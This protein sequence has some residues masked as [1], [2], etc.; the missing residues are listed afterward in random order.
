MYFIL[1]GVAGAYLGHRDTEGF[2]RKMSCEGSEKSLGDCSSSTTSLCRPDSSVGLVCFNNVN[3]VLE[4]RLV[5]GPALRPNTHSGRLEVRLS[6]LMP[7]GSVCDDSFQGQSATAA[8]RQMGY[9][10]GESLRHSFWESLFEEE[11]VFGSSERTWLDEVSCEPGQE[12]LDCDHDIWGYHDCDPVEDV[13]VSC[14]NFSVRLLS[15][16]PNDYHIG[17]VEVYL[18]RENGWFEV[19]DVDWDD[20]DARVACRELGFADGRALCCNS[21]GSVSYGSLTAMGSM[22]NFTCT[23]KEESLTECGMIQTGL[24][25][26]NEAIINLAAVICYDKPFEEIDTTLKTRVVDGSEHAGILEVQYMGVWGRVCMDDSIF[27]SEFTDNE[28]SVACRMMGKGYSGGKRINNEKTDDIYHAWLRGLTCL[29]NESSIEDCDHPAWGSP[30]L[31]NCEGPVRV[32]CYKSALELVIQ[33]PAMGVDVRGVL[34]V[35]Y[36]GTTSVVCGDDWGDQEANAACRTIGYNGGRAWVPHTYDHSLVPILSGV[37][38]RKS[39]TNFFQ[40]DNHGW[41]IPSEECITNPKPAGIACFEETKL[42]PGYK[43]SGVLQLF[44]NKTST[45]STICRNGFDEIDAM[46]A[47]K[48]YGFSQGT[49][50]PAGAFGIVGSDVGHLRTS[51]NCTGSE[52]HITDCPYDEDIV[53]CNLYGDYV[54]VSC[55]NEV[56]TGTFAV[57]NGFSDDTQAVGVLKI[58]QNNTWG[59]ACGQTFNELDA[60][61]FCKELGIA[62]GHSYSGGVSF[63]QQKDVKGPYFVTFPNCN[64]SEERYADCSSSQYLCT[65]AAAASVLCYTSGG[66]SLE[67]TGHGGPKQGARLQLN[68]NNVPGAI[69]ANKWDD[70]DAS[71][72]CRQLSD[73]YKRGVATSYPR[74][75][76]PIYLSGF[77]CNGEEDH[78]FTCDNDGWKP[79][80]SVSNCDENSMEAGVVCFGRVFFTEIKQ[81]PDS[82]SGLLNVKMEDDYDRPVC[83]ESTFTHREAKAV[84]DE[85]GYSQAAILTPKSLDEDLKYSYYTLTKVQCLEENVHLIDCGMRVGQCPTQNQVRLLCY[86]YKIDLLSEWTVEKNDHGVVSKAFLDNQYIAAI[87]P[88]DWDDADADTFC[89]ERGHTGGKALG[90]TPLDQMETRELVWFG[91]SVCSDSPNGRKQC[92]VQQNVS[93]GCFGQN[94]RAGVLC[95]TGEEITMRLVDN[96]KVSKFAGRVE[97]NYQNVWGTIC[98]KDPNKRLVARTVCQQLGM[99]DGT[100]IMASPKRY[101]MTDSPIY[102]KNVDCSASEDSI[103]LCSHDGWGMDEGCTHENDLE[104]LCYSNVRIFPDAE[105]PHGAVSIYSGGS[106]V[107]LCSEGFTD[108]EADVIC[109]SLFYNSGKAICCSALPIPYLR[110]GASNAHCSGTESSLLDCNLNMDRESF[111]CPSAKYASVACS[112]E[113]VNEYLPFLERGDRGRV[114]IRYYGLTGSVCAKGFTHNDAKVLCRELGFSTG[115]AFTTTNTDDLQFPWLVTPQC[116]G[117]ESSLS[118]CPKFSLGMAPAC[119]EIATVQCLPATDPGK[120]EVRIAD[121]PGAVYGIPKVKI[122]GTWGTICDDLTLSDEEAV[123]LCK[124]LGGSGGTF[125]HI[126]DPS[127][128]SRP[129]PILTGLKC[130]GDESSISQCQMYAF[131]FG[132]MAESCAIRFDH[133]VL[134]CFNSVELVQGPVQARSGGLVLLH[135]KETDEWHPV[136]DGTISDKEASVICKNFGYQYGKQQCCNAFGELEETANTFVTKLS[137]PSMDSLISNCSV[138]RGKACPTEGSIASVHCRSSPFP[139]ENLQIVHLPDFVGSPT[140]Q[141]YGIEGRVCAEG[142]QEKEANVICKERGYAKGHMLMNS[143]VGTGSTFMVG[144]LNCSGTETRISDCD[145]AVWNSDGSCPNREEPNV[146]CTRTVLNSLKYQVNTD[147][148]RAEVVVDGTTYVLGFHSFSNKEAA[149]F[150]KSLGKGYLSG[151]TLIRR[152]PGTVQERIL[153]DFISCSGTESS[154]LECTGSLLPEAPSE[155][156]A[157]SVVYVECSLGAPVNLNLMLLLEWLTFFFRSAVVIV[158][159]N[160]CVSSAVE[161]VQGPVQARSGGLVLLH[162]KETDEWHPVCDGTISDKEASVICK[163]FGY[164]YGKQQCCNAFGELEETANTFVTKLSCPSMDSLISNCSVSRGK[165]CPTEGS[166]ASVHCRSSPFPVENLQIVHLPDFVGSPTVQRYGIEGRVCA[167]GFQEKEANVICKE[168]GY[169]KGHML[170]NS[171]VGTGSTFMVGSLNCSGTETRISDCDYAVW[172]SDGSCPNREEPN[173]LCTRTVLNSLKYQVNTDSGRA[174]V[175]VDGTTYVLGFHS[176]SNKEAAVFCKSLGKGYLS[177][178]TLIRRVPGTVQERILMDFISC[179]GTESSILECTG[180]LLPEAPSEVTADSVVY[181]ECSLGVQL[182]SGPT[183]SSGILSIFNTQT[184]RY[185]VVCDKDFG[186]KEADVACKTLGYEKGIL[187]CCQAYGY[188][189]EEPLFK[190]F[191]CNGAEQSILECDHNPA[192]TRSPFFCNRQ[193]YVA[194]TC[195]KGERPDD[196][197]VSMDATNQNIQSGLVRVTYLGIEGTICSDG[198]DDADANVLCRHLGFDKGTAYNHYKPG[199]TIDASEGPFWLSEISCFGN[200]TDLT[201]CPHS[202]LGSVT[203]CRNDHFAGAFCSDDS[204]VT[205]RLAG[206]DNVQSGRVEVYINNQWGTVCDFNW[207]SKDAAVMCRMLG[208]ATGDEISDTSLDNVGTGPIW[209]L[210]ARCSGTE[211][212]INECPHQGWSENRRQSCEAHSDD[213]AVF[214]YSSVKLERASGMETNHGPVNYYYSNKWYRVCSDGFTDLSARLVCQEM[215]FYD[216]RS[217]CCSAYSGETV[218]G[219]KIL[220]NITFECVGDETFITQCRQE[221]ECI[222]GYY[223]SVVCLGKDDNFDE[224]EYQVTMSPGEEMKGALEVSHLGIK[225]RICSAGWTDKEADVFCKSRSFKGG[226]AYHRSYFDEYISSKSIGP[227]LMS[228]VICNGTERDLTECSFNDRSNLGNCSDSHTAAVYCYKEEGIKYRLVFNDTFDQSNFGRVEMSVDGKWGTV[229]DKMWNDKAARVVCRGKKFRDGAAQNNAPYGGGEGPI[230]LHSIQCTGEEA[231][232]HQCAHDGFYENPNVF[233]NSFW[234][235]N[236]CSLHS[237]DASVFCFNDVKLDQPLEQSSGGLLYNMDDKWKHICSDESFSRKEAMVACKSLLQDYVDGVPIQKGVFGEMEEP[238]A[239]VSFSC[240]GEESTLSECSHNTASQCAS[241]TYM[242]VACFKET[243][244]D[245]DFEFNLTLSSDSIRTGDNHGILEVRDKGAWGRICMHEFTDAEASVA[246]KSLNFKGGHKYLHL[247]RNRLPILWSGVKCSGSETSLDQCMHSS[248]DKEHCHY[249]AN[250]AGVVCYKSEGVKYRLTGGKDQNSGRVEIGV[251][252]IYGSICAINWQQGNSKVLCRSMGYTDGIPTY[253]ENPDLDYLAPVMSFFLCEGTEDSLLSCINSG[254]DDGAHVFVC[255]GSAYASCFKEEVQITEVRL[256][257]GNSTA[258]RLEVYVTPLNAWGTV[259]DDS[260]DDIDAGVACRQMGFDDGIVMESDYETGTG[261]I[262]LDNVECLGNETNIGLCKSTGINAHNCDHSEDAGVVC[263]N[264]TETTVPPPASTPSEVSTPKPTKSPATTKAPTQL[265]TTPPT[266]PPTAPPTKPPAPQPA[267]SPKIEF[268]TKLPT[269]QVKEVTTSQITPTPAIPTKLPGS[270]EKRDQKDRKTKV[271]IAA[272]ITI[273]LAI[274]LAAVVV[275]LVYKYR[276]RTKPSIPHERFHDDIIEHSYDG[277]LTMQNQMYSMSQGDPDDPVV[278]SMNDGSEILMDPSGSVSFSKGTTS[279]EVD[280]D[281]PQE[282]FSNP[283]YGVMK[284]SAETSVDA[285]T[286]DMNGSEP[287]NQTQT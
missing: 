127:V 278:Q 275:F 155:V 103:L 121:I 48:K 266:K 112:N 188:N 161:L 90:S 260:W 220:P 281:A 63:T 27:E 286:V 276:L 242:S 189:F 98:H 4:M 251:D 79:N 32:V 23:G 283:L 181:V 250:D 116:L 129:S 26:F 73:V 76:L 117:V 36:D 170:M 180:S 285:V 142:F 67:I 20:N 179:S 284:N 221:S 39:E 106:Y 118:T 52:T 197:T 214:C 186:Q 237:N 99:I 192:A 115:L 236:P 111:N 35:K 152:V 55:F 168:R 166:I 69:C 46:V 271:I 193:D 218:S 56:R 153:M 231:Y 203:H 107:L 59:F 199:F 145:Y 113:L 40:C 205:Y 176:F 100:I 45:W 287:S 164:Q 280:D 62:L 202:G 216:G 134:Q 185:G 126:S 8:C 229:C 141:R 228:N 230:W 75:S 282:G 132:D 140:V 13:G 210:G 162:E 263:F 64:G 259:C 94:N 82:L 122:G 11:G 261:N 213:A 204:I 154:I 66:P 157:D 19:C 151:N 279:P 172:N 248:I 163:N 148:G 108:A 169:A 96:G 178:N 227:L 70:Q 37:K 53:D 105:S 244:T 71:V 110:I 174:E 81:T 30:A 208:Y 184:D 51:I 158:P 246:C 167:E 255:G 72:A 14:S 239:P 222:S 265:P 97:I 102:L 262:F 232:L 128:L 22:T 254:F 57:E 249:N 61:V 207:D 160:T 16:V 238:L 272:C 268:T 177:G 200:E 6:P 38:C 89:A 50:L 80:P 1:Q 119:D 109:R 47:C 120:I 144:S 21:L 3:D 58:F 18:E 241:E 133:A 173:V 130:Q 41:N 219:R 226:S 77:E 24:C 125:L 258:G 49:V 84:C 34:T 195:Y 123:V 15:A 101:G 243:L 93:F 211:S 150:C 85:L 198:W 83:F 135:E 156:T 274:V 209:E 183:P 87:C 146:L 92:E 175:V 25:N 10:I 17:S 171:K 253:D 68:I 5:E 136:C 143:K 138:S 42:D 86:E 29:G 270:G 267:T 43:A 139:V 2:Y 88:Q 245:S 54:S 247:F 240:S 269:T 182:D 201:S 31:D 206:S 74:S 252:G 28:A 131:G 277:S 7:W 95:Y 44:D 114:H 191:Q 217:L 264:Y 124:E 33:E 224:N 212:T 9:K 78:L 190:D 187:H 104:V 165:A 225:G 91:S 65:D 137:C 223:A 215:G 257:G 159:F 273:V 12:F 194:I 149:V 256:Q 147:S 196:F 235:I 234:F 233:G 60:L